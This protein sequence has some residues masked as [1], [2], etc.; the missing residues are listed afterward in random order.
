MIRQIPQPLPPELYGRA[1]LE[2]SA[3]A[4]LR[5]E[6]PAAA[7]G[8][9]LWRDYEDA[10][11]RRMAERIIPD[12]P[13]AVAPLAA[14]PGWERRYAV[15]DALKCVP[16]RRERNIDPETGRE[17]FRVTFEDGWGDGET[18]HAS[19]SYNYVS[20]WNPGVVTGDSLLLVVA[21]NIRNPADGN[22][23]YLIRQ[24]G[25]EAYCMMVNCEFSHAI[26]NG[27]PYI[28]SAPVGWIDNRSFFVCQSNG[29]NCRIDA[30]TGEITFLTG[31][32]RTVSAYA[33]PDGTRLVFA[34]FP[35]HPFA[36][37][38]GHHPVSNISGQL[39]CYEFGTGVCRKIFDNRDL[40]SL[41]PEF[42]PAD[43]RLTYYCG[44]FQW[45]RD[46][47]DIAFFSMMYAGNRV[48]RDLC[49]IHPDGSGLRLALSSE[50]TIRFPQDRRPRR[51]G[52]LFP[53]GSVL[54]NH[55][56]FL[57]NCRQIVCCTQDP[58]ALPPGMAPDPEDKYV[59]T[60]FLVLAD[61]GRRHCRI[62]QG[63]D[64]NFDGHP[65]SNPQQTLLLGSDYHFH[66][67]VMNPLDGRVVNL[68][69]LAAPD[70]RFAHPHECW[71]PD[72]RF[73]MFRREGKDGELFTADVSFLY[74]DTPLTKNNQNERKA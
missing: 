57:P 65:T 35:E 29:V 23:I 70:R 10:L 37:T 67:K 25:R 72:G 6:F 28:H 11:A 55:Q 4:G 20:P 73:I 74:T 49:L 15:P 46:S 26:V 14:D 13:A 30:V 1:Y 71:S 40:L 62:L 9:A 24:D 68:F 61:T 54:N 21:M 2:P 45:S 69:S 64:L 16:F 33:S 60:R 36:V 19:V 38:D 63:D 66:I 42:D 3:S 41:H 34:P 47:R 17:Y 18:F 5:H 31:I 8:P 44:N 50:E 43:C 27:K 52:E 56:G 51:F 48:V 59:N 58:A 32:P 22:R 39:W 12:I 7:T 53:S